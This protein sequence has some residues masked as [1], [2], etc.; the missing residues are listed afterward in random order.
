MEEGGR[1]GRQPASSPGPVTGSQSK[2]WSTAGSPLGPPT[3]ARAWTGLTPYSLP[4]CCQSQALQIQCS[5]PFCWGWGRG[6]WRQSARFPVTGLGS[7]FNNPAAVYFSA[8]LFPISQV[9]YLWNTVFDCENLPIEHQW[10]LFL[11]NIPFNTRRQSGQD[12]LPNT[13]LIAM[14]STQHN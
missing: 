6:D 9:H 7:S 1:V 10:G 11:K 3:M 13:I 4:D 12:Y 2:S 5:L 8:A 14:H